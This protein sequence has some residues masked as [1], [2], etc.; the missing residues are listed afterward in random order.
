MVYLAMQLLNSDEEFSN[1]IRNQFVSHLFV[2]EF[3]DINA[4]QCQFVL[5]LAKAGNITIVGDF[6]QVRI[7]SIHFVYH[8]DNSVCIPS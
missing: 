5:A 1:M 3:Q 8:Y 6:D 2:D 4:I 7:I